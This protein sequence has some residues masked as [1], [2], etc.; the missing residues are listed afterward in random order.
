M[1]DDKAV[2]RKAVLPAFF[3]VTGGAILLYYVMTA[4]QPSL[5]NNKLIYDFGQLMQGCMEGDTFYQ[6]MWF[7]ADLTEPTFIAALPASILMVIMGFVA[8]HLERTGSKNMGTGVDGNH[9]V[10]TA[11]VVSGLISV[12]LGILLFKGF[13]PT[14]WIPTF[15]AILSV[16]IFIIFFGSALPKVITSIIFGTLITFPT[17][18]FFLKYAIQPLGLPLFVSVA[19]GL[20]VTVPLCTF[21]FKMMPWMVKKDAALENTEAAPAPAPVKKS[22]TA[23]F[24]DRVFGDIG[25]L[26]IWGSSLATI[27]L[28]VGAI[29]AWVLNPLHPTYAAGNLPMVLCVQICTAALAVLIYYPKWKK[30]GWAFTF[31]GVVFSSAIVSTY[32]NAWQIVV[33]TVAIGALAF[34]P[35]IEWALKVTNYKGWMHVIF[36]IQLCIAVMVTLWSFIVK[37]LLIPIVG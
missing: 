34:A 24:I 37:F 26:Q 22:E 30:E 33:P 6:T 9:R 31:A 8:A 25:E 19:L 14:G 3:L 1:V 16:P 5:M 27:G 32:P 17:C 4:L 15:A 7:F 18:Y 29:I 10:F 35:L 36:Y 13:F 11:M 23:F 2:S 21:L 20:V 28:Y 12:A